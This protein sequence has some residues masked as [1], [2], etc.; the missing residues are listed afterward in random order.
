MHALR[1]QPTLNLQA[2]A[3]LTALRAGSHA[4]RQRFYSQPAADDKYTDQPPATRRNSRSPTKFV[5][6]S[7]EVRGRNGIKFRQ[8][9]SPLAT[10]ALGKKAEVLIL[11]DPGKSSR[12]PDGSYSESA[13]LDSALTD[14]LANP[15]RQTELSGILTDYN[16][17]PVG[18]VEIE[19]DSKAILDTLA[20]EESLSQD[21]GMVA[22]QIESLRPQILQ[23]T[24]HPVISKRA[25]KKLKVSLG[26][27]FTTPQLR[28]YHND[29][30]KAVQI[31]SKTPESAKEFWGEKWDPANSKSN[32]STGQLNKNDKSKL[33]DSIIK[34]LWKVEVKAEEVEIGSVKGCISE[35]NFA[36][37]SSGGLW[38]P[39]AHIC[40]L[41]HGQPRR[42][43]KKSRRC[44]ALRSRPNRNSKKAK[45][46]RKTT[47]LH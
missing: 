12:N 37:L 39:T 30:L 1:W 27:S 32:G 38:F 5:K 35:F 43:W 31:P 44:E 29:L 34:S 16:E 7:M 2:R 10:N 47:P 40:L 8:S 11:S 41:T 33:I 13:S 17:T 22:K 45:R 4:A 21:G 6:R 3:A 18:P 36:L 46:H 14:N 23:D 19:T 24:D 9:S 42:N 15:L 20:N 25:F 28:T 26:K